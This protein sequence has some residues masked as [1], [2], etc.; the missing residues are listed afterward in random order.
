MIGVS[1]RAGGL[2]GLV[3]VWCAL[4]GSFSSANVLSGVAIVV[5]LWLVGMGRPAAGRVRLVPLVKLI[6]LVVVDLAQ[7]TVNVAKAVVRPRAI[8][9]CTIVVE[10]P[11]EAYDHLLLVVTAVTLTPG[12]A[13]V[14]KFDDPCR[15][16]LH[17]LY[18][19][20]AA[21]VEAHVH[22]LVA[23]TNEAFGPH[24]TRIEVAS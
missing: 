10:L 3:V 1:R 11:D 5:A 8:E 21:D 15:L 6:A 13:V 16:R 22:Q 23:L 14:D 9:E 12:T 24:A 7:S 20:D 19:S 2:I 17:L 4:W 18:A